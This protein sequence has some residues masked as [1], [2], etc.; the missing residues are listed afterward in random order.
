MVF[1]QIV[2][3]SG[4]YFLNWLFFLFFVFEIGFSCSYGSGRRDFLFIVPTKLIII[5]IVCEMVCFIPDWRKKWLY[6]KEDIH[7]HVQEK[8]D[9]MTL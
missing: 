4:D 3:F 2:F 1:D 7:G 6:P 5:E 8:E 9:P